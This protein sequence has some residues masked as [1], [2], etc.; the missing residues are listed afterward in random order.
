MARIVDDA[1]LLTPFATGH[2]APWDF[3]L[4]VESEYFPVRLSDL[5]IVPYDSV[6]GLWGILCGLMSR[7]MWSPVYEG[8]NI[9]G[10]VRGQER[11]TLAPG[12]VIKYATPPMPTVWDIEKRLRQF[13]EEVQRVVKPMAVGILPLGLHPFA[14]PEAVSLVPQQRYHLMDAYMPQVGTMGRHMMRLTCAAHITIDFHTE[15]DA[16]RKLQLAAK[17]TPFF[18]AL[19]ANSAVQ[20]GKHSGKASTRVYA[21]MHTDPARTGF[22]D[23]VF[24]PQARFMDYAQWALDVPLYFLERNRQ[25][26]LVGHPSFRD[27]LEQGIQLPNGRGHTYATLADWQHHLSIVFPWVRLHKHIEICAFDSHTPDIVLAIVALIKGLFYSP[28][29]LDAVEALVGAYDRAMLEDLLY[30]AMLYG[31]DAE[32]EDVSLRDMLGL[33]IAIARNGLCDQGHHDYVFLKPFESLALKR[34]AEECAILTSLDIEQY[35]RSYLL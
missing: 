19:S 5:S 17:L 24:Q 10:L 3:L 30:E 16:M 28:S 33:F 23:C 34:R 11:V 14:T 8:A 7:Y 2:T 26:I 35:I 1:E 6:S 18:V 15:A 13:L 25:K 31:L 9:I 27:F 22:P 4:G 32:V 29:S 21:W 20:E 12:G